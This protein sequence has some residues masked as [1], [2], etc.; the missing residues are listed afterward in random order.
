MNRK[1]IKEIIKFDV[2][3]SIQNKWFILLNIVIFICV[4]AATNWSNIASFLESHNIDII[5]TE[6]ISIEVLDEEDLFYSDFVTNCKEYDNLKVKKVTE[7]K[8]SKQNIPDSDVIFIEVTRDDEAVIKAKIVSKE[9]ISSD[10]YDFIYQNLK[11]T[12]SKVFAKNH[13]MTIDELN[14]LNEDVKIERQMLGVNIE[15]SETKEVIKSYSVIIVYIVLIFVLSRIA[16]EIAQEKVSK[17]IEYVLTSVSEKEYLLAKVLSSTLTILIQMLYIFVYYIIGNMISTILFTRVVDT[18]ES[19]VILSSID[20]DIVSYIIAMCAYL[21]FTVFLTTLVQAALSSRT[22]SVAEAGNTTV[23]LIIIVMALYAVSLFAISPYTKASTFMYIISCVP[24]V[25][26]FFV[27]SMM[28][29]GQATTLQI[30]ISF[31]VLILSVPLIFNIC[32]KY[33]KEGILDYTSHKKKLFGAKAK[34]EVSIKEKQDYELRLSK[35]KKFAFA[36]GLAMIILVFLEALMSFVCQVSVNI[37]EGKIS[38]GTLMVIMNSIALIIALSVASAFI[39]A[40]T[41]YEVQEPKSLTTL[42]KVEL[43]FMGIGLIGVIQIFLNWLYP[44]IGLDYSILEQYSLTPGNSLAEKLI[45]IIGMALVPAIFEELLFRKA[46]LNSSK[47]YGNGFAILFSALLFGLYHFNLN[48]GIFAFIVGIIFGTIAVK[49]N[50]TK[51]TSLLHFLNNGYAAMAVIL[52]DNAVAY[53]IFNNIVIALVI[54]G[55]VVIIKNLPKLKNIKKE[56][57]NFNKDCTLLVKN[58]TFIIAMVLLVVMFIS[59]E[60]L[61]VS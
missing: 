57:F 55:V 28:I 14:V 56:D 60:N 51:Y 20:S 45:Y 34:K 7:N 27:P 19:T 1:K 41:D 47:R 36:I 61:L 6:T 30:V 48:Q 3:K 2:E 5:S 24:I 43:I 31:I 13:G 26:T 23:L 50:T 4:L 39:K 40:Y 53:G 15:N 16:N 44:K 21:I 35:A 10:I 29:I 58:Y 32:A 11:E 25:S 52:E 38:Y 42:Q 54:I 46:I 17:S 59:T 9:G 22:T 37:F 8:Y 33:F 18:A 12:R 49:T